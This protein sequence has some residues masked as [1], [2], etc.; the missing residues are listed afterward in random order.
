ME[1]LALKLQV[2][3]QKTWVPMTSVRARQMMKFGRVLTGAEF[4]V[5]RPE[6]KALSSNVNG[7]DET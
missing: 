6:G 5:D 2:F 4:L 1:N 7:T 3:C